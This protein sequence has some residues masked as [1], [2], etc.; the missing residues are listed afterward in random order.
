VSDQPTTGDA[1][2]RDQLADAFDAEPCF[3]PVESACVAM[4]VVQP[5]LDRQAAEN[6]LMRR[7]RDLF[8]ECAERAEAQR[9]NARALFRMSCEERRDVNEALRQAETQV[10]RLRRE[11]EKRDLGGG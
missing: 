7:E 6:A 9:D 1:D 8:A 11:L 2:L 4:R 10:S 3:S 5:V